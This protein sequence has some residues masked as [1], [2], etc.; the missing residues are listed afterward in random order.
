M[1]PQH[2]FSETTAVFLEG[3]QVVFGFSDDF[4]RHFGYLRLQTPRWRYRH[5]QCSPEVQR[6]PCEF[7]ANG[8]GLQMCLPESNGKYGLKTSKYFF[9]FPGG[10]S[11]ADFTF[12]QFWEI[13][14]PCEV[15]C[16]PVMLGDRKGKPLKRTT[17]SWVMNWD[18]TANIVTFFVWLV[19]LSP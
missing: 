6:L 11:H 19:V 4:W 9:S 3:I 12:N 5:R 2:V 10:V 8:F 1:G 13:W 7:G 14:L 15:W 17:I 16:L 18:L